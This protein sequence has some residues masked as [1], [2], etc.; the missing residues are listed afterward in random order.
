MHAQVLLH[1]GDQLGV[2]HQVGAVSKEGVH[3]PVRAGQLHAQGAVWLVAHVAKAVFHVVAV[4]ARGAEQALH[5]ARQAAG[6]AHGNI[7]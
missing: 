2:R 4:A 7:P 5:V 3:L 1:A 6:A